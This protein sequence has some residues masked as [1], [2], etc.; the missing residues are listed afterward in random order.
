MSDIFDTKIKQ[1][2]VNK[3]D[4]SNLVKNSDLHRK[5]ET[6]ATE[7]ELK[8]Q[9]DKIVKLQTHDLSYFLDNNFFGDDSSQNMF[10]YQPTFST[11]QIKK[12]KALITFS[13]GDQKGYIVLFFLCNIMLFCIA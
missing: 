12:I 10:D 4:I 9:Q 2:F 6:L 8:A 5:I 7:A 1:E 11:L 3:S 13:V